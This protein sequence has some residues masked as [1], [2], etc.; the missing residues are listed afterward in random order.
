MKLKE[1]KG[2]AQYLQKRN[3]VKAYQEAKAH[4][5][6]DDFRIIDAKPR[7]PKS[8]GVYQFRITKKYRAF[9]TLTKEG[10]AV[11][12]ISDHQ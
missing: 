6:N 12:K 9:Y 4:F 8:L 11:Y 7:K 10:A 3:L 1:G 5:E 2:V